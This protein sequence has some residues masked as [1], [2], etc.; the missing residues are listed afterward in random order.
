MVDN[1]VVVYARDGEDQ[2]LQVY[3]RC[4]YVAVTC[5]EVLNLEETFLSTVLGVRDVY[6]LPS[7]KSMYLGYDTIPDDADRTI[8]SMANAY[9]IHGKGVSGKVNKA[10][11]VLSLLFSTSLL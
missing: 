11:Q 10:K 9:S 3:R 6:Y 7:K 4:S 1:S 5:E 2:D 8:G